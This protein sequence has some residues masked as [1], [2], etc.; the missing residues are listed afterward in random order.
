MKQQLIL[1]AALA[2]GLLLATGTA[3]ADTV[4]Y[5]IGVDGQTTLTS[6]TYTGL[7]NPNASHLTLLF[8]HGDHFHGIGAYSYSGSASSP[9]VTSTNTNNRIPE[10]SSA[11]PPLPL[12]SGTGPYAG[13]LVN[14]PGSSE[15]SEIEV[16]SIN[17][18][19]GASP[20]S[21]ES[22]LFNSSSG[23][24]SRTLAGSS[25]ALEL[26]SSTPGLYIG[27]ESQVDLFSSSSTALLGSGDRFDFTPVFSTTASALP[28]TYSATLRLMDLSSTFQPSGQFTFDFAVTQPVPEPASLVSFAVGFAALAFVAGHK[29]IRAQFRTPDESAR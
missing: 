3:K 26:I 13:R 7:A 25:L 6:G 22:V 23:R 9:V 21:A 19:A 10:V 14:A 28:G 4:S 5:Y 15:Y 12:Q 8:N 24:W 11:E 1:S 20:G 29:R 18:L 2:S 17:S 16:G 27:S